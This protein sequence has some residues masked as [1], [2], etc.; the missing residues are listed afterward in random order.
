MRFLTAGESH[1]R[2]LAVLIEG[3]P[4]LVAI[5]KEGIDRELSRRQQ[6]YGRGGRMK[7][8]QDRVEI[9]SGLRH[10]KTLGSPIAFLIPNRDWQNWA[11]VMDPFTPG[12]DAHVKLEKDRRLDRVRVEVT[13]PRPGH[14]DLAGGIKYGFTDLRNVL[15]RASARETAAR[16]GAGAFVKVLLAQF[17]VVIG[18]HVLRIGTVFSGENRALDREE[19]EMVEKSPVRCLDP[20]IAAAMMELIDK[21][22]NEGESL[23]GI[24]LVYAKGIPPGLGSH[25]H[26]DRRLDGRLARAIMSIP[27]VKGVEFGLGFAAAALGGSKVHDPIEYRTGGGFHRPTN[28]AGGIE[29]G[30]SN[31]EPLIMR[32]AMK[33]IPTLYQGLPS[34]DLKTRRPVR[35]A[36]ERS[37]LT[38]VPAAGVVGEAMVA[39]TLAEA[40]VEKF[41]GDSLPEMKKAWNAYLE[42]IPWQ[43]PKA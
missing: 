29:G 33:P 2:A 30:I 43:P 25:V 7:V 14:A 38:A 32:A 39:W 10:G 31:G 21:A 28:N 37:D 9:I 24:F 1:G 34:V 27:G 6:G 17:G 26:W 40:F 16:V 12:E 19:Q 13:A 22:R 5:G 15:E 11:G 36:A 18:S 23:G 4:A 8:E 35:A 42:E 20:Q 41:G 3:F